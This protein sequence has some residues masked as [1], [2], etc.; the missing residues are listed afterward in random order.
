LDEVNQ[1]PVAMKKD[2]FIDVF[3][4]VLALSESPLGAGRLPPETHFFAL[5]IKIA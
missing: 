4:R 3:E 1:S 5:K 2:E